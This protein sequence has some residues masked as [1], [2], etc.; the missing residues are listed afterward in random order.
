MLGII[1]NNSN[2][3]YQKNEA[4]LYDDSGFTLVKNGYAVITE[5][6]KDFKC[7]LFDGIIDFYKTIENKTLAD[8]NLS[9]LEHDKTPAE[10]LSTQTLS[11][12]YAYLLADFNGKAK[13]ATGKINTDFL[14][15]SVQVV[16]LVDKIRQFTGMEFIGSFETNPDYYDLFLTYPKGQPPTVGAAF[17]TSNN[18]IQDKTELLAGEIFVTPSIFSTTVLDT[19]K[20]ELLNGGKT[21][22]ALQNIKVK[23]TF[24]LNPFIEFPLRIADVKFLDQVFSANGTTRTI[25]KFY[26]LSAGDE[27]EFPLE[28][29]Y[30]LPDLQGNP[31]FSFSNFFLTANV[32]ELT[33]AVLFEEEFAGMGIKQ[34]WQ[35]LLWRFNLTMFNVG[36]NEYELKTLSEIINAPS[37]DWSSKFQS[38]DSENYVYGDYGQKSWLRYKYNDQNSFFDDGNLEINNTNLPAE[39]TVIQSVTYRPDFNPSDELGFS[40][41]LYRFWDKQP[42]D[43]TTTIDYKPLAN[44]FYFLKATPKTFTTPTYLESEVISGSSVQITNAQAE[45]KVG[46][47]FNEIVESNYSEMSTLL[48][49]SKVLNVT[50]RLDTIDIASI[51]LS[52]PVYIKQL[53]GNFLINKISNFIPF[54]DTKV[55][56]IKISR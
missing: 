49:K 53:G 46:L 9:D 31:S 50:M 26:N 24:T 6:D 22:K 55:E 56:L 21:L 4:Y 15:P 36:N 54:R 5:T 7:N 11:K 19:T 14:I 25:A 10:V 2:I 17:L 37:I 23:I 45:S 33:N 42:K 29:I 1:G 48:N 40:T 47:S 13:T 52:R 43:G 35:E 51:D 27:L 20:L 44:R 34:F 39:K 16:W 18:V 3:P 38:L 30:T 8:L 32:Q 28:V 12:P 41:N